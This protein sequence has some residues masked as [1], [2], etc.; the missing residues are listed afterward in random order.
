[1][2]VTIDYLNEE[3]RLSLNQFIYDNEEVNYNFIEL[4]TDNEYR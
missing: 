2:E 3:V 4:P 1:M